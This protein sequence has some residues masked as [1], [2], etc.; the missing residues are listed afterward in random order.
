M[1]AGDYDWPALLGNFHKASN[2]WGWLSRIFI[3]EGA[4]PKVSGNF[5][6]R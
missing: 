6:R 3:R 1:T 5:S 4:Y 2:S